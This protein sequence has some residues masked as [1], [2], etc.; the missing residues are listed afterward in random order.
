MSE[1]IITNVSPATT[2][3]CGVVKV[4]DG[5]SVTNDGTLSA[6]GA[7]GG[8]EV[9]TV[10]KGSGSTDVNIMSSIRFITGDF[11]CYIIN[12]YIESTSNGSLVRWQMKDTDGNNI[13]L[14]TM[15]TSYMY[16]N[17]TPMSSNTG[18][19]DYRTIMGFVARS[20]SA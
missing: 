16:Q 12:Y 10:T 14:K 15:G 19:W 11:Y 20:T 4:G 7:G 13:L 2:T 9:T 1:T 8:A 3:N 17:F 6:S 5:L 18:T